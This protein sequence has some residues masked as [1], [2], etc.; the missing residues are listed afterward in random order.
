MIFYLRYKDSEIKTDIPLSFQESGRGEV[1]F[2][3]I[4]HISI[5]NLVTKYDKYFIN[6]N[7]II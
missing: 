5:Y 2:L 4:V 7:F 3:I 1:L 6:G